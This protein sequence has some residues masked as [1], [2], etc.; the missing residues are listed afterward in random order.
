[1]NSASAAV[2][3]VPQQKTESITDLIR[4]YQN[5]KPDFTLQ[6][7]NPANNPQKARQLDI[8]PAGEIVIEYADRYEKLRMVNEKTLSNALLKLTTPQNKWIVFLEGHGERS[9]H[10]PGNQDIQLFTNNLEQAGIH[11]QT[12]NLDENPVIPN[13]TGILVIASPKFDFS[14]N[15][16]GLILDYL[17]NGGNLLWLIEPGSIN[18]PP[19]NLEAISQYLNIRFLPGTIISSV[20]PKLGIKNPAIIVIQEYTD[21]QIHKNQHQ[22][23]LLPFALA[24]QPVSNQNKSQ[25]GFE[26]LLVTDKNSWT[27]TGPLES[28]PLRYNP[29]TNEVAGPLTT[30]IAITRTVTNNL[31][32]TN[33]Q[34]RI[35]IIGDGDFL[36]NAFLANGGNQH[37]GNSLVH[38][39]AHHDAFI[40]IQPQAALDIDLSLS[41]SMITLYAFVFPFVL[42][43]VF[44]ATG[45]LIRYYRRKA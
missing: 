38:W 1:M 21:H 30:G 25:W 20:S 13:N 31:N 19:I 27:E 32:K 39:L 35:A 7:V 18:S 41:D 17:D 28:P 12:L 16:S 29:D 10:K 14:L 33:I 11:I 2:A 44:F 5:H 8:H 24:L 15:E 9:P 36:S 23:T 45:F 4:L 34:Q 40:D 43:F 6:F 22:G 3:G 42:P 37:L 26:T